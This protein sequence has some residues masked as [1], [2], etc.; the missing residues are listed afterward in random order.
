VWW[1]DQNEFDSSIF[2][3]KPVYIYTKVIPFIT[4]LKKRKFT[5]EEITWDILSAPLRVNKILPS[6][7]GLLYSKEPASKH[8]FNEEIGKSLRFGLTIFCTIERISTW[9]LNEAYLK[10]TLSP[11]EAYSKPTEAYSKLH[12]RILEGY[13]KHTWSILG[14][15]L[16]HT[17]S[18]L[19]AYLKHTWSIIEAYLK[20]NRSIL[21]AYLKHTWSILEPT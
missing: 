7:I 17:W 21:E 6:N 10:R 13:L 5:H 16:E 20:H 4:S 18:I 8:S 19:E 15:Y 3:R 11:T 1:N 12:W 9:S 2:V 14:A